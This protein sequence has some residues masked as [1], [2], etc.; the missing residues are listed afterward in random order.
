MDATSHAR[1]TDFGLATV[2]RDPHSARS[3]PVDRGHNARWTAPEIL[4][5]QGLYYKEADVFSFAMVM[6]EVRCDPPPAFRTLDYSSM[7]AFTGAAPF[8]NNQP[9][10]AVLAI[11]GGKRPARPTHSNFTDE[12]WALMKRCWDP[13]PRSRPEISEVWKAL[14]G[15]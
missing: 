9:A 15:L 14:R 1:I 8:G 7:Q 11:M 10:A 3:A 6:I 13:D 12:L 4:T 2:T 5:G